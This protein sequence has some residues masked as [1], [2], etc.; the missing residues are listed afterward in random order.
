MLSASLP[1]RASQDEKARIEKAG[2]RVVFDGYANYRVYAKNARYPGRASLVWPGKHS[3][4]PPKV[5]V[6]VSCQNRN[7]SPYSTRCL[8]PGFQYQS[9]SCKLT[10]IILCVF[11]RDRGNTPCIP[12]WWA[13]SQFSLRAFAPPK[14]VSHGNKN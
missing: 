7:A 13:C 5:E 6:D 3:Q 2:G 4:V 8:H 10:R 14:Y 9:L 12:T 11:D 1:A